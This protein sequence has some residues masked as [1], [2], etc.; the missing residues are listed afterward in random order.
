MRKRILSVILILIITISAV[1]FGAFAAG[2]GV[3][4]ELDAVMA[5]FPPGS[6]WKTSFDG[7][8]QCMGFARMVVYRIFGKSGSAYRSWNY[9]GASL[10]GMTS[11]GTVTDFTAAK[12]EQLLKKARCGDVLQYDQ[13]GIH[14]MIVC[15]VENDGVWV[16]DCN[17]DR[18]CGIQ[19]RKVSFAKLASRSSK[20]LSLLRASNYDTINNQTVLT[21]EYNANG[22]IIAGSDKTYDVYTVTTAAGL[23]LRSGAGISNPV[24]A[25]IPTG[26]RFTVLQT[27]AAGGY[28][29][30]K[31]L[32]D[33]LEGWCVISESTWV[34]KTG[35]RPVTDYYLKND[36]IYSSITAA[37]AVQ[38]AVAG[39]KMSGGL[40]KSEYF[41]LSRS[42]YTFVGWS[43][44]PSGGTVWNPNDTTLRPE[45]LAPQISGGNCTVTLYAVWS[46]LKDSATL[47]TDVDATKW[48]KPYLDYAV[49]YGLMQGSDGQMTPEAN[50]TR[51]QFVQ[52]L[53]NIAGVDTSD[54]HVN[55]GFEDVESGMW[56]APAI[57]WASENG[58]VNGLGDGTFAPNDQITREQMCTM[59]VRYAEQY[60]KITLRQLNAKELF[61]DDADISEW[62]KESV[63]LCRQ[64]GLVNGVTTATFEPQSLAT[65][66]QVATIM[67][68][69]HQ[70]YS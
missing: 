46:K 65:R 31:V 42:G 54:Y 12:M 52:V 66:A 28:T 25:T 45:E 68:R 47:F 67:V 30:G 23:N 60:E 57:K 61:D 4:A 44:E 58:I 56:F 14:T 9:A 43:T 10:V 7:A 38:Q 6:S 63:Y 17:W 24:K 39:E 8:T 40:E 26:S 33:E 21:I 48:Y 53:A 62:A 2:G 20:K 36:L 27:K 64:A 51:A 18:N 15:S 50:M 59:L 55:A 5:Q 16:Y 70:Q 11:V 29:W 41:G 1:P 19:Y 13:S 3:Q 49:T 69:Y 22:G 34:K 37:A 35:T 32:Y